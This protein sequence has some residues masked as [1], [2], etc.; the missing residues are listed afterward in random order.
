[1]NA[2]RFKYKEVKIATQVDRLKTVRK[3]LIKLNNDKLVKS[4]YSGKNRSND[5]LQLLEKTGFRLSPE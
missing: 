3:K 1:M 4:R 5:N 2:D